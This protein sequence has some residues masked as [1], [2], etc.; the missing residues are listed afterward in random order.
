MADIED[1]F[2]YLEKY[3]EWPSFESDRE[4]TIEREFANLASRRVPQPP[5]SHADPPPPIF[6]PSLSPSP[7][8]PTRAYPTPTYSV[9]RGSTLAPSVSPRSSRRYTPVIPIVPRNQ[10]TTPPP[11]NSYFNADER[12]VWVPTATAP[13]VMSP[14]RSRVISPRRSRA[15]S[16]RLVAPGRVASPS[17]RKL[18]PPRGSEGKWRDERPKS[19]A[20]RKSMN[21]NCFLDRSDPNNLKYPIC[22]AGTEKIS[23]SSVIAAKR[24]AAQWKNQEV[25]AKAE[26]LNQRY[27]CTKKARM[28]QERAARGGGR[29]RRGGK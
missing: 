11:I 7:L 5:V 9:A 1:P 24:R 27:K 13:V 3:G 28:E 10:P 26:E 22:S 2:D 18:K 8:A 20:E 15:T 17:G 12:N 21:P 14:G 23:C 19:M 4:R 25:L 16:P 29:Q 6:A